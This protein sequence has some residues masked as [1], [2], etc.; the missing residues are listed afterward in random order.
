MR[1][2]R[3]Q[4]RRKADRIVTER[5]H[6]G[7]SEAEVAIRCHTAITEGPVS[8]DWGNLRHRPSE[9]GGCN[10]VT[11]ATENS[12]PL[13]RPRPVR[14]V[15]PPTDRWHHRRRRQHRILSTPHTQHSEFCDSGRRE[16]NRHRTQRRNT[17]VPRLVL[18]ALPQAADR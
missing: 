18:S 17:P 11:E 6:R 10:A 8:H 1:A 3:L 12:G 7:S 2:R 15:D 4:A 13:N 5:Y 9:H 16:R 14:L